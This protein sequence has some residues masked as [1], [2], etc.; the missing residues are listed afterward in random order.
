VVDVPEECAVVV[1][2]VECLVVAVYLAELVAVVAVVDVAVEC[3]ETAEDGVVAAA[4]VVS[5]VCHVRD[6]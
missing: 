2:V 1:Q 4:Q 6:T 5:R 3:K